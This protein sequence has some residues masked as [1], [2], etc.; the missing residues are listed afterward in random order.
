MAAITVIVETAVHATVAGS[1][2]LRLDPPCPAVE[3]PPPAKV[4]YTPPLLQVTSEAHTCPMYYC[5]LTYSCRMR[6][7]RELMLM[8]PVFRPLHP[9]SPPATPPPFHM[10]PRCWNLPPPVTPPRLLTP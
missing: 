7:K 2:A 8:P 10:S 9:A 6:E 1:V 5:S 3:L 4:V